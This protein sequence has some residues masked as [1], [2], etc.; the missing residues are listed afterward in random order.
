MCNI[1]GYVGTRQAAPILVDMMRRQEGWDCGYYTG[2]ATV[3]GGQL[4]VKK[5]VGNLDMVLGDYDLT[6]LPGTTGFLHSRTPGAKGQ[7]NEHWAHPFI[8]RGGHFAYIVNGY[9]GVFKGKWSEVSNQSYLRLKEDGYRFESWNNACVGENNL[10]PDGR[11]IHPTELKCQMIQKYLDSGME[12]PAAMAAAMTAIPGESVA[13]GLHADAPDS[14]SWCR[15][16]YPMFAGFADHG[17]YLAT[18]P[19]AMPEDARNVTLLNPLSYGRVY[20]DRVE[21]YPCLDTDITIATITPGT[22]KRCYESMEQAMMQREMDHGSLDLL[23]RPLFEEAT[24]PPESA[25]NYAIMDHFERT[26][27]LV[28]TKTYKPGTAPGSQAPK[29]WGKLR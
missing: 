10:K 1:A 14:V 19:Q 11:Y 5:D 8:G 12:T 9:G 29:L 6:K 18:T 13:L 25:V 24:C 20:R 27:R 26:G 28:I 17:I 3:D 16:N 2:L 4:Y 7:E 21:T 23:I 15:I 22:W